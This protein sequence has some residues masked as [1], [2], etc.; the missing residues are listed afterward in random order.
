MPF[1]TFASTQ[2]GLR[3]NG[4]E[5][6]SYITLLHPPLQQ[7]V[8]SM[9]SMPP[10]PT[11]ETETELLSTSWPQNYKPATLPALKSIVRSV[12]NPGIIMN[13]TDLLP[14]F[15]PTVESALVEISK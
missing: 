1:Q 3:M 12:E 8:N 13:E 11:N 5:C 15:S 10:F 9:L 7:M 2:F 14:M 4:S 6:T